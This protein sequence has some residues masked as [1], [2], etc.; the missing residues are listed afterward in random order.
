MQNKTKLL[1]LFTIFLLLT[2]FYFAFAYDLKEYYPCEQGNKWVYLSGES[3]KIIE[4]KGKEQTFD[5]K[6]IIKVNYLKNKRSDFV[7]FDDEGLKVY[8]S[9]DEP[10]NITTVFE[11]PKMLFPA[12]L[13][14]GE[15]GTFIS[16]WSKVPFE[17]D[18][19]I[20]ELTDSI[21]LESDNEDLELPAGKF[22]NCLKFAYL[23]TD[24]AGKD[25]SVEQKVNIWLAPGIGMVKMSVSYK[26]ISSEG[27]NLTENAGSETWELASAVVG[28][29]KIG[30]QQGDE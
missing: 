20:G 29:K 27:E 11:P 18:G 22:S 7:T 14:V 15:E 21:K 4:I 12:N 8:K 19:Q 2:N 9:L 25:R 5:G 3:E 23:M 10:D 6:E 28:G 17:E 13:Q 1:V 30:G 24:K 26:E 16:M